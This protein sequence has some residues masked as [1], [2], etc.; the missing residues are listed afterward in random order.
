MPRNDS[1][2]EWATNESSEHDLP[3]GICRSDQTCYKN[4]RAAIL[5][6]KA[7]GQQLIRAVT[8]ASACLVCAVAALSA[9][10]EQRAQALVRRGVEALHFFEYEEANEA[11]RQAQG[12]EPTSVMA[13]WGEAMT[14]D[15]T[16]WR[17]EDTDAARRALARLG[18][19]DAARETMA[20]SA[21]ERLLLAAVDARFGPGDSDTRKR[22]YADAM[23]RL[24]EQE[25]DDPD[26]AAFYALALLGRC[27]AA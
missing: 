2:A 18:Q 27:R 21:K 20:R 3:S 14:Y 16:L 12:I 19:T 13:V 17:K 15:Q 9:Q 25:P 5:R 23:A 24:Y 7:G 1:G 10:S 26:V 8:L 11:F 4:V 22:R 6:T